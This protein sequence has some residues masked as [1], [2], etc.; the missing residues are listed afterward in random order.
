MECLMAC[1]RDCLVPI[2]TDGLKN[3]IGRQ[4]CIGILPDCVGAF[5]GCCK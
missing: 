3:C 2:I 5:C 4:G 1:T